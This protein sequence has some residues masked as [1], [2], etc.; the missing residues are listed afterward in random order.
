MLDLATFEVL[1]SSHAMHVDNLGGGVLRFN[2]PQIWLPDST[3]NE[4][5]SHG[6]VV[7]RISELAGNAEGTEIFNTAHIYFDWNEPIVTN[8][9]YNV[10]TSLG[11]AE[12]DIVSS[13]YPNPTDHLLM[14]K[15]NAELQQ[16][17]ITDLSG[18]IVQ[19]V[20]CAG[21]ETTIN[22][23]HCPAGIYL[24]NIQTDRG[25]EV[26]RVVKK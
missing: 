4:A 19:T 16:L 2:F 5:E 22:L 12:F 10:N 11:F 3:T 8:T 14:V 15:C 9:T 21:N 13:I 26:S 1:E 23:E 6:H 18:K 17:T 20:S 25:S 24:V 7:Y